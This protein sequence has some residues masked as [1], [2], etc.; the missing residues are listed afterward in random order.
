MCLCA[1]FM[2][3][4]AMQEQE[5]IPVLTPLQR[6]DAIILVTEDLCSQLK[7]SE[8]KIVAYPGRLK[9]LVHYVITG[10]II[11]HATIDTRIPDELF[12]AE[13]A[14]FMPLQAISESIT[15]CAA[16]TALCQ[17]AIKKA[18]QAA[19]KNDD[20]ITRHGKNLEVLRVI[21]SSLRKKH[22]LK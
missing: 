13:F 22:S 20:L 19:L 14:Q 7:T 2:Y 8:Q 16:D 18:A 17:N 12:Y 21:E 1:N 9:A 5:A 6:L 15:G 11:D 4:H 3:L 10:E